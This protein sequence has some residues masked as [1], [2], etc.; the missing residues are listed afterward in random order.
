MKFTIITPN[1][2]GSKYLEK[3]IESVLSQN[4]DFE[5]IVV[6][7]ASTDS[8]LKILKKYPHLKVIS[9]KDLGMYDAV[10]KGINM[11]RGDIISYI[12]CDDRYP[13][14]SLVKVLN[15][16]SKNNNLDYVYGNC[17]LI[18]HLENEIYVYKVPPTFNFLLKVI[19]VVPWAQPSIFYKRKV[20]DK[21][22]FFDIKYL[23]AADYHFMKRVI[24]FGFI[25]LRVNTVLSNFMIRD[26]S[27][28]SKYSKDMKSEGVQIKK[29]LGIKDKILFDFLYNIYRKF[30]NFHIFFHKKL[31]S[32]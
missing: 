29:V 15:A 22:G 30:Y 14:G 13:D 27:L 1:Y 7:G 10:N 26:D 17:R 19:T 5:H 11:A 4:V 32:L 8:S 25:S 20:F 2:N 16:F 24:L 9:E 12:N 6:D 21:I 23:L 28:G 31:N 3:C 18:D